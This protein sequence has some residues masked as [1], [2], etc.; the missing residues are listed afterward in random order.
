MQGYQWTVSIIVTSVWFAQCRIGQEA[1][2]NFTAKVCNKGI[3]HQMSVY[4]LKHELVNRLRLRPA[5]CTLYSPNRLLT[6]ARTTTSE[7][8]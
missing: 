8:V 2:L 6:P 7:P 5:H 4:N 1:R 3:F